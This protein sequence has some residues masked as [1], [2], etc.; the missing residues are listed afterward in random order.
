MN[1]AVVNWFNS[2]LSDRK[3]VVLINDHLSSEKPILT[4]V[5]QGSVLGPLL[6]LIY[7]NTLANL[8]LN[9]SLIMYADDT[10]VYSPISKKPTQQEISKYQEDLDGIGDWC[11]RNKL[12]VN[13][14]KT[15]LMVLGRT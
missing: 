1:T 8:K 14:G 12:S 13:V 15:K 7:V 5:P 11:S 2:Y 9:A 6:F 3:Q 10:V 4:G